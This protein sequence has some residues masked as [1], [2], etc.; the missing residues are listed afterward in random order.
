[1][2]TS[3][4]LGWDMKLGYIIIYVTDVS[5][6]VKQYQNAFGL[7]VRYCHECGMYTELATG[8]TVLAFSG[9][10]FA[11]CNGLTV[12]PN[13][14][15]DVAPAMHVSFTVDDVASV[16]EKAVAAGMVLVVA[17]TKKPWGQTVAYLQD[18]NGCYIEIGTQVSG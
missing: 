14:V 5:K 2:D 1:M 9:E 18:C 16:C 8:K 4:L 15:G 13:R 3:K 17:P 10:G 11:Q 7:D 12:K 6:T